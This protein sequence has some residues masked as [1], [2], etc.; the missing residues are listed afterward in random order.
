MKTKN[1][2][3]KITEKGIYR[4]FIFQNFRQAF[5]FMT[6]VAL[7]AEK[8]NHHPDWKNSF[9]IVEITYFTHDKNS[10]TELDWKM[11][12]LIDNIYCLFSQD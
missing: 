1:S 8:H 6:Q 7:L 11:S 12:R 3:W 2:N 4:Q 9:K 10:I 5:G